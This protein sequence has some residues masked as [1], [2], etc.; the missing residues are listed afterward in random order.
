MYGLGPPTSSQA[1]F[2]S[3][4]I[5]A[6]RCFCMHTHRYTHTHTH[7]YTHAHT[8]MQHTCRHNWC[9]HAHTHAHTHTQLHAA[10][11]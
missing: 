7:T 9:L 3:L 1:P 2:S 6:P 5:F 8:Y 11:L 4:W 10:H